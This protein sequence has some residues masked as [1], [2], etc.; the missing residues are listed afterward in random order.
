[1]KKLAKLQL[2][3]QATKLVAQAL[4]LKETGDLRAAMDTREENTRV[5][6]TLE[7]LEEETQDPEEN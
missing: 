7:P 4:N 6:P 1:M 2:E 5:M 3:K